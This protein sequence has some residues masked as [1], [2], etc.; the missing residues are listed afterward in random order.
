[1]DFQLL[2]VERRQTVKGMDYFIQ[3]SFIFNSF[4]SPLPLLHDKI[5]CSRFGSKKQPTFASP[6]EGMKVIKM[7]WTQL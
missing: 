1:M 2:V 4:V 6:I 3:F 5:S 7:V